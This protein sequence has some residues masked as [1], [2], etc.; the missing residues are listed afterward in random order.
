MHVSATANRTEK[1]AQMAVGSLAASARV[2]AWVTKEIPASQPQA[3]LLISKTS[4]NSIPCSFRLL[5]AHCVPY[6]RERGNNR[7]RGGPF[8]QPS[9]RGS[10]TDLSAFQ[11]SEFG[12]AAY[13]H[14]I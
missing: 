9:N 2:A 1:R 5:L 12:E 8:R 7:R 13:V 11:Q 6:Y 3:R 4:S 14:E 10:N